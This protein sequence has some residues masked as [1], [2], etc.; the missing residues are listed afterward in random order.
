MMVK[1]KS[2]IPVLEYYRVDCIPGLELFR[3]S[4]DTRCVSRHVHALFCLTIVEDGVRIC[5]S[6]KGKEYLTP[7]IVFVS[8]QGEAHSGSVPEGQSCSCRSLRLD[9]ERLRL[10]L[11]GLGYPAPEGINLVRPLLNDRKLFH[12]IGQYHRAA[13]QTSFAL[14][15]EDGLLEIVRHLLEYHASPKIYP[16]DRGKEA[17]RMRLVCAYLHECFAENVSIQKV[18]ALVGLSP[19]YLSRIFEKEMGVPLHVYQLDIRL[20]KAAQ[21]L[22]AGQRIADVALETGFFDQS[23]FH[24]AFLRKFGITPKQYK[25][26]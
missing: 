11:A 24:K 23:H 17:A 4:G 16:L 1:Q 26:I 14:N 10:L 19:Y 13:G 20:T 22:A 18:S 5:Q 12:L 3:S 21:M 9:P 15:L 25:R 8:N 2:I 7:G 6:K